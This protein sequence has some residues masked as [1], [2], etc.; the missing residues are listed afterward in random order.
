MKRALISV[1]DKT[2]IVDFTRELIKR[3]FEIISTSGTAKLLKASGI[4]LKTIEEL[5]KSPEILGGRVKTLHP[6]VF[7]G[8]LA[9]RNNPDHIRQVNESGIQ[10]FDLVVVNLYPFSETI[11]KE[12][13]TA[14]E[15]I[16]QIDIG[17]VSLIRAAAKNYMNVSVLVSSNQFAEYVK[18]LD[19][20]EINNTN[21]AARAFRY[22][23]IYDLEIA[24]YFRNLSNDRGG[25]FTTGYNSIEELRYGEN[26]H[27]KAVLYDAGFGDTFEKLHG[28]ELSYINILDIDAAYKLI[29]EFEKPSCVI[30]KHTNP[31]G[32]ASSSNIKD[33][34]EKAFACD[35]VSPFGG[36]VAVNRKLDIETAS[37]I[38]KV[39]TE[40]IIAPEYDGNTLD[41]LVKKKNRRLI[42]YRRTDGKQAAQGKEIKSVTGGLLM[43]GTDGIVVNPDQ[44]KVVT[45]RKPD[46]N[47][48]KDL[49]FAMKVC[50]H[51]RSNSVI[52]AKDLRTCGIGGGQPSRVDSSMLA[53]QKAKRFGMDLM[54]SAVASDAFFP[55][56]D[57]VIE[58][59]KAGARSVIQPGGSMRDEE[60]IKAANDHDMAMI[61]TGIRHF[62]H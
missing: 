31:S 30:I 51:T 25:I 33:A 20:G 10:L 35:T 2:G 23:A 26:P 37:E 8:L 44:M 48:L 61:F 3:N 41:F 14:E 47:E 58:A 7:A 52:Y 53:V 1:Y 4:K 19:K 15:A 18:S 21:L 40:I 60:V 24:E 34:Y 9:D 42:K 57:G 13:C 27:Q 45:S 6:L 17:G 38:D 50:K 39:F 22:I 32:A 54:G 55:F 49:I 11:N 5:T 43:Q 59:A 29:N 36:I 12:G 16:E 56:P 62:R 28:K 46:D